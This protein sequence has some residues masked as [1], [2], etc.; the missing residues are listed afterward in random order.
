M[1]DNGARP[2][3]TS[4][5]L[6]AALVAILLLASRTA[7][8]EELTLWHS[9]RGREAEAL[10]TAVAAFNEAHG[11]Q[12]RLVALDGD[13]YAALVESALV[14][15]GSAAPDII[16][17]AH[18]RIA[19]WARQGRLLPLDDLLDT[20]D[21]ADFIP[22]CLEPLRVE[23][24]LYGLP[25]SF[26]ALMLY[27]NRDLVSSPPRT[28]DELIAEAKRHANPR[29][30]RWGLVYERANFYYHAMWL[31]AFGG[32]V[33]EPSGAFDPRHRA[34]ARSLAFARD[35]AR[36]H[37]IIPDTVDW[38]RQIDLFNSGRAAFLIS[39]PWAYGSLAWD[40]VPIGIAP[41][42]VHSATGRAT[43]PFLGVK[44]FAVNARSSR[45]RRAVAAIQHLTSPFSGCLMNVVAGYMPAN[46][47]AYEFDAL[48]SHPLTAR[49]QVFWDSSVLMPSFESMEHVW[50]VMMRDEATGEPGCLDR[51]F[52]GER[53]EAATRGARRRWERLV[54]RGG[55]E[56]R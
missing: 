6:A 45:A 16:V 48:A 12:V 26:E 2:P 18:D 28:T 53:I 23:G 11:D 9:F 1:V 24:R 3:H 32:R 39:G 14:A 21:L 49:P 33:L 27:Y 42:P 13:R 36:V 52:A 25:L 5:L 34:M 4:G 10:E 40:R 44:A 8:A 43:A 56:G 54:A 47:L 20:S 30:D 19:P 55:Q 17:W 37:R 35:L 31:H 15:A 50:R 41:L 38:Q 7:A 46:R 51:V 22:Q 29:K